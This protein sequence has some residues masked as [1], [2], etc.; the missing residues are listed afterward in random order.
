ML[1]TANGEVQT[2]EDAQGFVHDLELFVK[3]QILDDTPTVLPRDQTKEE[4]CVQNG[5]L[6]TSCCSKVVIQFG[7]QSVLNID[8]AGLVNVKSSRRA[9]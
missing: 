2:N 9:T 4:I 6:R 1:V 8:I 7:Y 3:V 5:K